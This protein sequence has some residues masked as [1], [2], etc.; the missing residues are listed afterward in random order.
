MHSTEWKRRK[1]LKIKGGQLFDSN[2]GLFG[3]A[4]ENQKKQRSTHIYSYSFMHTLNINFW[5]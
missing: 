5:Q 1:E 3:L 4:A 2:N